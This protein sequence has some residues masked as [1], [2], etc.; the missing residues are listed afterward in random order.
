M[1]H[2]N[3]I[4]NASLFSLDSMPLKKSK[5]MP[6]QTEKELTRQICQYIRTQYPSVYFFTDPSGM[7][8][9]S[10]A[11]KAML[12]NNRS[13]HAQL[14]IIILEPNNLYFGAVIELKRNREK[15]YKKDGEFV[16]DHI[17]EQADSIFHLLKKRYYAEFAIGFDQAKRI[18]DNYLTPK[19][20]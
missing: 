6:I 12:K 20:P 18:I 13:K 3:S 7:Y 19:K 11:A 15:I 2:T 16:S 1:K 4:S 8:Q 17:K 10:W 9:K 14:D 5:K